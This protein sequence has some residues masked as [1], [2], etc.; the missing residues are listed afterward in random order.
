MLLVIEWEELL[1]V[2]GHKEDA[3][4]VSF[5]DFAYTNLGYTALREL[6]PGEIVKMNKGRSL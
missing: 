5:E 6:G 1:V 3:L 4:Y 2:I